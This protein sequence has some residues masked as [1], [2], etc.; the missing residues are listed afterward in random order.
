VLNER[1]KELR[2]AGFV[3]LGETGGY[4]LT[5]LGRELAAQVMPLHRFAEKWSKR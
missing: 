5:S 4:A 1:L 2:E 3:E